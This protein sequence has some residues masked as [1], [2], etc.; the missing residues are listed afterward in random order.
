MQITI[1]EREAEALIRLRK[2]LGRGNPQRPEFLRWVS[3][4]LERYGD[5]PDVDFI[6]TLNDLS[7]ELAILSSLL[8]IR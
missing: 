8:E 6:L 4:R 2:L 1:T 7:D 3:A 5:H